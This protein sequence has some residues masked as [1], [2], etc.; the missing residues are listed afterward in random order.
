[1]GVLVFAIIGIS[2]LFFVVFVVAWFVR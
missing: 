2:E 1:V